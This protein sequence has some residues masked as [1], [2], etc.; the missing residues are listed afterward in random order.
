MLEVTN[1]AKSE[2]SKVLSAE[3]AK[4]K[5]LIVYFQGYG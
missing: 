2:L 4:D 3:T 5:R 1:K